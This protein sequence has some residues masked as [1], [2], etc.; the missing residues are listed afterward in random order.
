VAAYLSHVEE[1]A[2]R[3]DMEGVHGDIA[4]VKR[5]ARK[6][7]QLLKDLLDLSRIGHVLSPLQAVSFET[8]A[9]D[10]VDLVGGRLR[11]RGVTVTIEPNLPVV[12]GDRGRLLEVVQNLLDNAAKFM[13]DEPAP[14]IRIGVRDDNGET[15]LFIEDNGLGIDPAHHERIFGLFDKLDP[16]AEGTGVGLALVKRIV[17]LHGGRIWVES[18][19]ALGATF[20]LTLPSEP[21]T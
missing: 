6:M 12:Y 21:S 7:D 5:A 20:C 18:G 14:R 8:L 11:D 16:N 13:G 10:A 19:G 9:K 17:E 4:R 3:G 1:A 2:E 15:V